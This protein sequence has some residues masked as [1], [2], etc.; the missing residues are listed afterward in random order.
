MIENK[1]LVIQ[2]DRIFIAGEFTQHPTEE[3]AKQ[4]AIKRTH[5]TRES[6]SVYEI[7]GLSTF[8]AKTIVL[9]TSNSKQLAV[10]NE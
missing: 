8:E 10:S 1:Y 6:F 7:V 3:E 9:E 2:T 5:E 4:Y